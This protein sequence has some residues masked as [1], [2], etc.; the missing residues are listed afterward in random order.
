MAKH[1]YDI[2][3]F[4]M[5]LTHEDKNLSVWAARC[6]S[7]QSIKTKFGNITLWGFGTLIECFP[8]VSDGQVLL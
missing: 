6:E 2:M 7:I 1:N 5:L 4:I 8:L 3:D